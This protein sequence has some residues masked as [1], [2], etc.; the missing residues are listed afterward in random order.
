MIQLWQSV[1]LAY[2]DGFQNPFNPVSVYSQD[3][4][5]HII[6]I[7]TWPITLGNCIYW[8]FMIYEKLWNLVLSHNGILPVVISSTASFNNMDLPWNVVTFWGQNLSTQ[9]L[10]VKFVSVM[11]MIQTEPLTD[12]RR[13]WKSHENEYMQ[14]PKVIGHVSMQMI[15][16]IKSWL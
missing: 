7:D 2:V 4:I 8:F 5:W 13:F 3:L 1:S 14:F 9:T 6:C 10:K 15:C 11:L 12:F 16:Q